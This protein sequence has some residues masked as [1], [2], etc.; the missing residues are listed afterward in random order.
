MLSPPLSSILS[1]S[2]RFAKAYSLA[3]AHYKE[4]TATMGPIPAISDYQP[5]VVPQGLLL[6]DASLLLDNP[7]MPLE[8]GYAATPDG[9]HHVAV[10]TYMRHCTGAM[11]D[12]WVGFI[13]HTN[14]Y[15]LWHPRDHLFSDWEGPRDNTSTYIGS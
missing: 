9:M 12:W 3:P 2:L 10:T 7:Y 6:K 5:T 15:L 1:R 11:I 8:S 4:N 14:Y 13:H